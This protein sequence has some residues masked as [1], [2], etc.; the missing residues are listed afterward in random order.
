MLATGGSTHT[1]RSCPRSTPRARTWS[2]RPM[3]REAIE[4]VLENRRERG[5]PI[6]ATGWALVEPVEIAA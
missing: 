6:P 4:L 2:K 3:V 1:S 5:E